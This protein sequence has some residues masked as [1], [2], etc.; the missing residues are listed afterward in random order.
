MFAAQVA[1]AEAQ[2][3]P[4]GLTLGLTRPKRVTRL[5]HSETATD[6]LHRV[7]PWTTK[8]TDSFST[9]A[10]RVPAA[11]A[12]RM[13]EI[14]IDPN[15]WVTALKFDVDGPDAATR[16]LDAGL[17]E[18]NFIVTNPKNGHA[19]IVY[20]LAAWVQ[21]DP[22]KKATQWLAAIERAYT[23]AL[24]SDARY[25]GAFVHNPL[26]P[27][28]NV[29]V[30]RD[31]PFT[32]AEL[33]THVDMH[34]SRRVYNAADSGVG[35]NVEVFD[36]TRLWAYGVAARGIASSFTDWSREVADRAAQYNSF[37]GHPMGSLPLSEIRSIAKS[38]ATWVWEHY[39]QREPDAEAVARRQEYE[40]QR[41]GRREAA[42][43]RSTMS[44]GQYV[45]RASERRSWAARWRAEGVP[46]REIAD[47]LSCSV[48]EAYRLLSAL[49][50]SV[51]DTLTETVSVAFPKAVRTVATSISK[52]VR[53]ALD[54]VVQGPPAVS[55][56]C[57]L[58]GDGRRSAGLTG[59]ALALQR[60]R[61]LAAETDRSSPST[62]PLARS[63]VP[64]LVDYAAQVI[65]FASQ[66]RR[67]LSG[68]IVGTGATRHWPRR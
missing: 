36:R 3:P 52:G 19:H 66:S 13:R 53:N 44:R 64:A 68:A 57:T 28:W 65:G 38:V 6:R 33:A 31:E 46:V 21:I 41:Q 18:P 15:G 26:S 14:S 60:C 7:L 55:G 50:E 37:D 1:S 16:W 39:A 48:R 4:Q 5:S 56:S 27:E 40:R 54:R 63:R 67:A 12:K 2:S 25:V 51:T 11:E 43:H 47:R 35:R 8:A 58:H 34:V 22:A 29:K 9:G 10:Y 42:R 23:A 20:L 30:A 62:S 61:E 59:I 17:P 32:L 45:A 24:Q 49:T